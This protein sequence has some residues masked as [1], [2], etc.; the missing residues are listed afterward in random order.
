MPVFCSKQ[1]AVTHK[2]TASDICSSEKTKY[3]K[4]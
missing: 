3:N 1:P 2:K 4:S